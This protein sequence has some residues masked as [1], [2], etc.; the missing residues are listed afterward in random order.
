V[1]GKELKCS[2]LCDLLVKMGPMRRRGAMCFSGL[3]TW[4]KELNVLMVGGYP[5]GGI[6]GQGT[7]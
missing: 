5:N 1:G 3:N 7:R 6:S 2:T 4:Y